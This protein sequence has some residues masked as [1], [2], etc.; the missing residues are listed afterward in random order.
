MAGLL[1][2]IGARGGTWAMI[3]LNNGAPVKCVQAAQSPLNI[4]LGNYTPLTV[5][6]RRTRLRLLLSAS[7]PVFSKT[8]RSALAA[9]PSFG[10]R[11]VVGDK[12]EHDHI[13]SFAALK[14]VKENELG[15]KLTPAEEKLYI[16]MQ[17]L[18]KFHGIHIKPARPTEVKI[19]LLKFRKTHRIFV[20][21]YTVIPKL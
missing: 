8:P 14:K 9:V 12:L 11:A 15:R 6:P 2:S 16:K 3:G 10:N 20:V 17:R 19:L 5:Q 13:P 21:P 7:E 1:V 4:M 18:L